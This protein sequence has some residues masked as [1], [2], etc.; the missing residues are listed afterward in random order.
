MPSIPLPF[1]ISL[2]LAL[3]LIRM[4]R[5]GEG[6]SGLFPVLVGAFAVQAAMAGLNWGFGWAPARLVQP[7]I[8]ALLPALTFAA[9][10]ELRRGGGIH[11]AGL[12]PHLM[13]AALVAILVAFWREPVDLVLF[14]VYLGYGGALLRLAAQ[15]PGA[16]MATRLGDE[17]T[18]H[19]ALIAGGLF[20]IL[21]A[22]VD[23]TISLELMFGE[24]RR[25]EAIL[26]GA[27]ALS[28][29]VVAYAATIAGDSRPADESEGPAPSAP[30]GAPTERASPG[31]AAE[32]PTALAGPLSEPPAEGSTQ[33]GT[34][35]GGGAT[36]TVSDPSADDAAIVR[37]IDA[38]MREH[39]LYRDADL[40]LER[41][42]RRAGI[43]GRQIS[44]AL[45]RVHGRNV[46]QVVNEYRVAEARRRLVETRESV[47]T[48][49]LES[50]FG[51]K[52]NFNREFLRVT[53]MT[54]SA[55]RR[56]GAT[57]IP[58]EADPSAE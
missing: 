2:V 44:A 55:Y 37:R 10:S 25:A 23:A 36:N 57:P 41:L 29:A 9:F 8:A 45:N 18:A 14:V 53:G 6:P 20:I 50:G 19:R 7:V 16:L 32:E 38:L 15:G 52:S 46:S 22:F 42:A 39:R 31:L 17:R 58:G 43:P 47:T 24:E 3:I 4:I 13:P 11:W 26:A 12:W 33:T 21:N 54:P 30:L 35:A 40:T 34:P 28:L 27:S 5:Q 1:V 49:M 56:A 48:V 51:T